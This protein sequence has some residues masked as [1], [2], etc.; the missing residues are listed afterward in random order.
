MLFP[1]AALDALREARWSPDADRA[2]ELMSGGFVWSDERLNDVARICSE[3]DNW[4][5]RC[6]IAY[7]ASLIR[8]EPRTEFLEPWN[9]LRAACPDWPGFRPD[10]TDHSLREALD[11]ESKESIRQLDH[12]SEV[13][14]RAQRINVIR[15]KRRRRWWRLF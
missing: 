15:E 6:V 12:M 13:C 2:F 14:E 4:A 3:L 10:R 8:D 11:A 1:D 5:F 9:Q 7:R